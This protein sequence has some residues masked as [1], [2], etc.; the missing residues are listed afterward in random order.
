MAS[1]PAYTYLIKEIT[2]FVDGDTVDVIIDLGFHISL[3]K[4]I[5]LYGINAPE[6][7]TR[8]LEEKKKGM[9]ATKRLIEICSANN[10][11]LIL[12]CHGIGKYGRIIG[13]IFKEGKSV[14]EM[15]VSEGHAEK[16]E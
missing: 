9:A 5:R 1:S 2:K 4:R 15:M 7:R 12:R 11:D 14:N 8:D 3:K 6:S 16:Y 10:G 13:E